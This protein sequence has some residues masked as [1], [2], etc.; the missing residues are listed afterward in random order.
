MGIE[1]YSGTDAGFRQY[2]ELLE[3][4]PPK[5]RQEFLDAAKKENAA[6]AEN[7]EK[8]IITFEK[9]TKLPEMELAEV[10]GATGLKA[11]FMANAILSVQDSS[12]KDLLVKFVPRKMAA[13][14]ML[15]MKDFPSPK[16]PEVGAARLAMIQTARKLEKEGK[17]KTLLIPRFGDGFFK[18]KF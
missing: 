1:R 7:I 13:E 5:K 14:V 16:P 18:K 11:E 3:T 9:I 8:F 6:F 17:L 4:T 10:F 12:V 15:L 2:V